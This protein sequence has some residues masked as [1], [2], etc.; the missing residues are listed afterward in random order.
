M[1]K[2]KQSGQR[3]LL[4]GAVVRQVPAATMKVSDMVVPGSPKETITPVP[5]WLR[6]GLMEYATKEMPDASWEDVTLR[7]LAAGLGALNGI[8]IAR[9]PNDRTASVEPPTLTALTWQAVAR[10]NIR[11]AAIANG[12][13]VVLNVVDAERAI[14][15][16]VAP[17][18]RGIIAVFMRI[19]RNG[20]EGGVSVTPLGRDAGDAYCTYRVTAVD[21]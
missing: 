16:G 9:R 3:L 10:S 8:V 15:R 5:T 11:S 13:S 19:V 14:G 1:R 2:S 6:D 21:D 12:G 17:S 18:R 20:P 7:A 4:D